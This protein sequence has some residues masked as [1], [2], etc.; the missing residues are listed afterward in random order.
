MSITITDLFCGAGGSSL[1]AE[2][3]GATGK[4]A[5]NHW[6]RAIETHNTNFPNMDHDCADVSAL[7]TARIRAY[8]HTDI[9]LASPECT[10]HSVAKGGKRRKPKEVNLFDQ[11]PLSDDAQD[12]S[13]ATMWDVCRFAEQ[14]QLA[15]HP[16]KAIIVENVVDAYKWGPNDNGQ[17]FQAW[18]SAVRAIGYLHEIVWLNSMFAGPVPQSRDRMYVVFWR[19]GARK[20][21]LKITPPSWC[22]TCEKIVPGVQAFKKLDYIWG[23]YGPQYFYTCPECNNPA[24]P[25]AHPAEE[26]IDW[27]IPITKIGDREKPLKDATRERVKRGLERLLSHRP[28]VKIQAGKTPTPQTLPL[29]RNVPKG[30]FKV[31]LPVPGNTFETT[32]GNRARDAE[33]QPLGTVHK[34]QEQALVMAP[35]GGRAIR[36]ANE[37]PAPT[38]ATTSRAAIVSP[39]GSWSDKA[40]DPAAPLP[41]LTKSESRAL[42]VAGDIGSLVEPKGA[43]MRN[44]SGGA[45]MSTPTN[46]PVRTL[47]TGG[48]QSV[49]VPYN[50]GV[51]PRI[52]DREPVSTLTCRDRLAMVV[53]FT[54]NGRSRDVNTDVIPTV[55]TEGPPAIAE[56]TLTDEDLDNCGFRMFA[57]PEIAAAMAMTAHKD[58]S[59]YIVKGTKR[60]QMAQYGNAV[61][62]PVM[63]VLV[64][65]VLDV[66]Q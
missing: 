15:G 53:P 7:T 3:A 29:V 22:P 64:G 27:S 61:T 49:V 4:L 14:K 56:V 52:S 30:D 60:E 38:Q 26:A 47:T 23:R 28:E 12:R 57:I 25:G 34:T 41:T 17:L 45:E 44:N 42:A 21:N 54:R 16:Y 20:P 32:P 18:L 11:E 43:V 35:M 10:N 59:A 33:T 63:E 62:P 46:E 55:A 2:V 58:G 24:I 36:P 39:G 6:A 50:K 9:L 31:V 8:P 51:E 13:R 1:G 48:H 66:I 37:A 5:L 65:R 19:K 40:T